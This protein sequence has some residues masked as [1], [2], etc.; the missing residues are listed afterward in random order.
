MLR[1]SLYNYSDA[2]IPVRGNI[3]VAALTAGGGNNNIQVVFKNFAS[4]T[5]C[6][7][8][9]NNTQIDNGKDTDVVIPMYNFIKYSENYSK[10][11]GSLW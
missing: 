3:T 7:K 10:T 6:I 9:I 4:F 5:N 1:S 8:E 11:S 2:Y